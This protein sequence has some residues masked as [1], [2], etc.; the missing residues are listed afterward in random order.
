MSGLGQRRERWPGRVWCDGSTRIVRRAFRT[1]DVRCLLRPATAGLR[2]AA[3]TR[4]QVVSLAPSPLLCGAP[5]P[6]IRA[7]R[8]SWPTHSPL[9]SSRPRTRRPNP[10]QLR[11]RLQQTSQP[12]LHGKMLLPPAMG[13]PQRRQQLPRP[14]VRRRP[15]SPPRRG[16]RASQC[17][18]TW[19]KQ[20]RQHLQMLAALCQ[21]SGRLEGAH[22]PIA[23][24]HTR[25]RLLATCPARAVVPVLMQGMMEL[26][27]KRPADPIDFLCS[28]LQQHNPKKQQKTA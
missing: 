2:P 16:S 15:A 17:A 13:R 25:S 3:A 28:Y 7:S 21:C 11:R 5:S 19:S 9:P 1:R 6:A 14:P 12:L 4:L 20:V 23:A 8:A 27:R 22:A 26:N 10:S 24:G 18:P